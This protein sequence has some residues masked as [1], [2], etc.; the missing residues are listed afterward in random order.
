[1]FYA[2]TLYQPWLEATDLESHGHGQPS[3]PP[4][5]LGV[6]HDKEMRQLVDDTIERFI[7][8]G[9]Q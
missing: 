6:V 1:M 3:Y 8:G 7:R 2:K 9:D 4:S 5:P